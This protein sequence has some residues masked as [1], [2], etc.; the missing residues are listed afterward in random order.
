VHSLSAFLRKHRALIDLLSVCFTVDRRRQG[1]VSI[2]HIYLKSERSIVRST[3]LTLIVLLLAF[4]YDRC[5]LNIDYVDRVD[6]LGF[7]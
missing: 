6:R 4:D 7:V 1:R 3:N 5:F 2:D